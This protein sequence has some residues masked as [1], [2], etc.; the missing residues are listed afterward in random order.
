[1]NKLDEITNT[2]KIEIS[3]QLVG[4]SFEYQGRSRK[5]LKFESYC[6]LGFKYVENF[7]LASVP[8]EGPI[9]VNL[10]FACWAIQDFDGNSS[11]K[12]KIDGR[13]GPIIISFKEGKYSIDTSD[14]D[15]SQI[16]ID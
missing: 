13:F 9:T 14:A 3:N 6:G 4:R 12:A 5:I 1:M 10:R 2:I 8:A 7:G 11:R 16:Q 15:F